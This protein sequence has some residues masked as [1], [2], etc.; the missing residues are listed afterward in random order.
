MINDENIVR[1]NYSSIFF[2]V[3]LFKFCCS[4][5]GPNNDLWLSTTILSLVP[6]SRRGEVTGLPEEFLSLN[7]PNG[8]GSGLM[9]SSLTH[10]LSL[11]VLILVLEHLCHYFLNQCFDFSL[12]N[13]PLGKAKVES[14]MECLSSRFFFKIFTRS[15]SGS[16]TN[17]FFKP[18]PF[19]ARA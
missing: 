16:L 9:V 2:L 15:K 17:N 6:C 8:F 10:V 12:Y 19:K 11:V 3:E 4:L 7:S 14:L 5:G 18:L 1:N 13:F